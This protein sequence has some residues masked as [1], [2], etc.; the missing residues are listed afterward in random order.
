VVPKELIGLRSSGLLLKGGDGDFAESLRGDAGEGAN[1][2]LYILTD[3]TDEGAVTVAVSNAEAKF[4]PADV[5]VNDVGL[6]ANPRLIEDIPRSEWDEF[7]VINVT[8]AFLVTKSVVP[9]MCSR[10]WSHRQSVFQCGT[11]RE[12]DFECPLLDIEGGD[13]GGTDIIRIIHIAEYLDEPR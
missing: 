9:G 7:M 10:L 8:S 13:H 6:G 1:R 12:F 5:L 11:Q 3:G 4:G 2:L